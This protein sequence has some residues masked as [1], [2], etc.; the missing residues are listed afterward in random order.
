M[1]KA[2]TSGQVAGMS[3]ALVGLVFA[4]AALAQNPQNP[5]SAAKPKST[6][7]DKLHMG[8]VHPPTAT[9]GVIAPKANTDPAM[10]KKPPPQDP[11]ETPVIPPP[12]GA[13][14]K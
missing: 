9:S 7:P 6:I 8:P 3:A 12:G 10:V 11:N 13:G 5:G 1:A 2:Q 14:A 4:A